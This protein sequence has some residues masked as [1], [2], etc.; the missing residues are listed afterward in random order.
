M[1]LLSLSFFGSPQIQLDGNAVTIPAQ[2]ALALLVYLAVTRAPHRRD[3]LA[4]LFWPDYEQTSA[5]TYLR[6]ALHEVTKALGHSWFDAS[7]EEVALVQ[8]APMHSAIQCDV[9]DFWQLVTANEG[10]VEALRQA[11]ALYKAEFLSGF[12]LPDC[13]EFDQW[14]RIEA[15][16]LRHRLD[17]ALHT[18]CQWHASR[19]EYTA[20]IELTRRRLALDPLNEAAHR[21]LMQLYAWSGQHAAGLRQYEECKR[22]LREGLQVLPDPETEQLYAAIRAKRLPA[23]PSSQEGS[24]PVAA[25]PVQ[26]PPLQAPAFLSETVAPPR[27]PT[28]VAR[29][30]ELDELA[31]ALASA[32]DGTGQLLFVIGGAGRGKTSLVQE[33][34]RRAQAEMAGLLV[35]SG[36]CNA[37]TGSGDPY[38]PFR[39]ILIA[40]AGDVETKWAGG[41][42]AA[43]EARRLWEAMPTT[44]P[45][46][47]DT[48]PDLLRAFVPM[49][50]TVGRAERFAPPN[51]EWFQQLQRLARDEQRLPL[52][53][54]R[55]FTQFTDALKAIALHHPLLLILEDLHWV[56]DASNNLLFHLSRTLGQSRILVVGTYRPNEL[57]VSRSMER[58]PLAA[59]VGEL[60]RQH[61]DIW[62]DLGTLS[63]EEGRAFVDAYV[64]TQPNRLDEDFRAALFRHTGGHALFTVEL[65]REMRERGDLIRDG[66][67]HWVAASETRWSVL[68]A[69]VEGVIERRIGR[70]GSDLQETLTVASIE[71]ESFT[72]EVLARVRGQAEF[73]VVQLLSKELDRQ[74]RLVSVESLGRV[75]QQRLTRYRF[76]HHLFQQ[77][78]YDRL[79]EAERAYLHEAVGNAM[80]MMYGAESAAVAVA[81][82]HH[83][84]QAGLAEKAV[85]YLLQA[86]QQAHHLSA[87]RE[88]IQLLK[89]A[90]AL[91]A[92]LPA[93]R[94]R[95]EQ[96][97]AL[98]LT[99]GRALQFTRGIGMQ[100]PREVYQRA[101]E[102]CDRVGNDQ[103]R[104]AALHGLF[105]SSRNRQMARAAAEQMLHFAANQ[106]N[107]SYL[108]SAHH[109]MG[110]SL[111]L[112]REF[113]SA[114]SHLE[115]SVALY[116]PRHHHDL[117]LLAGQDDGIAALANLGWVL[118]HLGYPDQALQRGQEAVELAEELGHPMS[119]VIAKHFA[120]RLHLLRGE[121]QIAHPKIEE[122]LEY[123]G[124][125]GF[126]FV[127]SITNS[128]LGQAL[129]L[130][131]KIDAAIEQLE[132]ALEVRRA[133]NIRLHN[134]LI[135]LDLA[136]AYGRIGEFERGLTLVREAQADI[137]STYQLYWLDH[138]YC[139]KGELLLVQAM[140][141]ADAAGNENAHQLAEAEAAFLYA[142][143]DARQYQD[144]A[145]ELQA[146]TGLC[147]LWRY[148]GKNAAAHAALAEVYG[149]F[150][151]GF[152]TADLVSAKELLH[153]LAESVA[154]R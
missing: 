71:G 97:L 53:E 42:I 91:L 104:F 86:G 122:L 126:G 20:A 135:L 140:A 111:L 57:M 95:D 118:W 143:Q 15:E 107:P 115:Q 52:E 96:E 110:H 4:A 23:P 43:E 17:E 48:A 33:F 70:L 6:Q 134:A 13:P 31:A 106:P 74:H 29:E 144:K 138:S 41:Q 51:A 103:D 98:C 151:E 1:P 99:L 21:S 108:V 63:P 114:R 154:D 49:R 119:L 75:G 84:E 19:Q 55:L 9:H 87:N 102:L 25:P 12:S 36:T 32:R 120:I 136:V 11:L 76:R 14:Q 139:I 148:Q 16:S 116:D 153:S 68:P 56:D 69:K 130:E 8:Q 18:L 124:E 45:A 81:L 54:R 27:A 149:W 123:S 35:A 93:T 147:R 112:D 28:F 64:D 94:E 65:L 137:G 117:L 146:M 40:L 66:E 78:L 109:V 80:E 89:R 105:S 142:L 50:A 44:L 129:L 82:A 58:H 7:R 141:M 22:L 145:G 59:I 39:E 101:H 73:E 85:A 26:R 100:E 92:T 67:G 77:Y 5:R 38:L 10:D 128:Y 34:A 90:S 47:V 72:A 131:G 127:L 113:V 88:A 37:Y 125:Q 3:T 79:T 62:L 121:A 46:L 24:V 30:R 133:M 132:R 60:K 150:T 61:G 152:D 2:K 83:F